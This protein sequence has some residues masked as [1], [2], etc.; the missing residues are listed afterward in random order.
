MAGNGL[1]RSHSE[2]PRMITWITDPTVLLA[3]IVLALFQ[4]LAALPW[5]YAV[6]PKGFRDT[7]SSGTAMAYVGGGLLAAGVALATFMGYKNDSQNLVWY[8]RYLYGA[9]LPLQL[10]I[11]P[12][13]FL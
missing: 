4:F 13:L 12:L 7:A 1:T 2:P 8:G 6:D 9:V 11:D 5:L 3:G 10:L